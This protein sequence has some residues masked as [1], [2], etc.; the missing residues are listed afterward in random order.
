MIVFNPN[1]LR[2]LN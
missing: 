1:Y 2:Y